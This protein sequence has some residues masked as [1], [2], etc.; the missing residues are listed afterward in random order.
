[1]DHLPLEIGFFN[2]VEVNDADPT[3]TCSGE[4]EKQRGSRPPQPTQ[5][6]LEPLSRRCPSTPTCSR[7]R[8]REYRETSASSSSGS[9]SAA[10]SCWTWLQAVG[11]KMTT[12]CWTCRW[13]RRVPRAYQHGCCGCASTGRSCRVTAC[14]ARAGWVGSSQRSAIEASPSTA[15]ARNS[16]YAFIA[17]VS[18]NTAKCPCSGY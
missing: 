3:D 18:S 2:Q 17:P 15:P 10:S 8:C 9:S 14:A 7:R 1:M 11:E 16:R 5:R 6:T 13:R 4:V 12:G